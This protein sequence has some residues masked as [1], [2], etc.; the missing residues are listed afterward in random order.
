MFRPNKTGWILFLLLCAFLFSLFTVYAFSDVGIP[1]SARAATLYV[2]SEQTFLY[3]KNSDARL[4][5]ASTTKIMTA[6]VVMERADLDKKVE[7]DPRAV[8]VEGSSLYLKSGEVLTVRELLYGLMLRSANDAAEALAC[9][10]AGSVPAFVSMMNEKAAALGLVDTHFETP[11]GLDGKEH[12]TTARELS[13][14]AAA[15]MENE[16][17]RK[18]VSTHKIALGDDPVRL[19]VNHNKL[20]SLYDG[21]VGVKTGFTK[22]SGR[23]LVGAA[24]REGLTLITVTLDAPN[25]WSDHE[26]LFD[27]GYSLLE[28]RVPLL[29]KEVRYT[30]PVIGGKQSTVTVTNAAGYRYIAKKGA[31]PVTKEVRLPRYLA[32]PVRKG[33]AVGSL[34]L[35]EGD[36]AGRRRERPFTEKEIHFFFFFF[37]PINKRYRRHTWKSDFRNSLPMRAFSPAEKQK[38]PLRRGASRSTDTPP[39]SGR[40]STRRATPSLTK[41]AA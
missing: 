14:I 32:A 18:I 13:Y 16:E 1:V 25:D 19:V 7:I 17:F 5:M 31:S 27:Y 38:K 37:A 9:E 3:E 11:H 28:G 34:L 40:K 8:G 33:D 39:R 10:V 12:Y 24:E 26:K 20:L 15:A 2:P 6:L 21:A 41:T 29:E 4:P 36:T 22:K 30:L 35:Y 23:C